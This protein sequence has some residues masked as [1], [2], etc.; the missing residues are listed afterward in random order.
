MIK[1]LACELS[2]TVVDFHEARIQVIIQVFIHLLGDAL[3]VVIMLKNL[4]HPENFEVPLASPYLST[5]QDGSPS[6]C[7]RVWGLAGLPGRREQIAETCPRHLAQTPAS[8]NRSDDELHCFHLH[9][10][11]LPPP[12]K[13]PAE[14][15]ETD[16]S[17][18]NR[19]P[20]SGRFQRKES[21]LNQARPLQSVYLR[22]LTSRLS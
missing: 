10:L 21:W 3:T 12:K 9:L 18:N 8:L 4:C 13:S 5:M 11:A 2:N 19:Q 15:G 22:L 14:R 17:R 1:R 20:V 6:C 16:P 7:A